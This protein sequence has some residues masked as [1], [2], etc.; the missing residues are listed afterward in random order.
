MKKLLKFLINYID[1]TSENGQ[2]FIIIMLPCGSTAS[3]VKYSYNIKKKDFYYL[4]KKSRS[5]YNVYIRDE[6][7]IN[8]SDLYRSILPNITHAIDSYVPTTVVADNDSVYPITTLHDSF[9]THP[10]N[11]DN[12][13][14]TLTN[15]YKQ[16]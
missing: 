14:A 6:E 15:M 12:L 11:M 7:K 2:K 16:A 1:L 13:Y 5:Y 10:N 9:S 4:N 3:Y 8:I